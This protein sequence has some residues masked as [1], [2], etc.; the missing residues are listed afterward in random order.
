MVLLTEAT[1]ST[2][3]RGG[4]SERVWQERRVADEPRSTRP[5]AVRQGRPSYESARSRPRL[6][7]DR[8]SRRSLLAVLLERGQAVRQGGGRGVEATETKGLPLRALR[9]PSHCAPPGGAASAAWRREGA[10]STACSAFALDRSRGDLPHLLD[11]ERSANEHLRLRLR[12][13]RVR[14]RVKGYLRQLEASSS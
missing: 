9:A 12:G 6:F 14:L 11:L 10:I 7:G 5:G 3:S 4:R 2:R 8:D 13:H 1:T